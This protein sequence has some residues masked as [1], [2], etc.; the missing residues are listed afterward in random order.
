MV[1]TR[2]PKVVIME[3]ATFLLLI[4]S[5][6]SNLTP[7]RVQFSCFP[8][9]VEMEPVT[10]APLGAA[11]LAAFAAPTFLGAAL[12]VFGATFFPRR[13]FVWSS[14]SSIIG[15]PPR[16]SRFSNSFVFVRSAGGALSST[17]ASS[18]EISLRFAVVR[19]YI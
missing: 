4:R 16:K 19:T 15:R 5:A 14:S 8:E 2:I 12:E 13:G 1:P 10:F 17:S 6:G 3:D 11:A 18:E 7:Q 9:E